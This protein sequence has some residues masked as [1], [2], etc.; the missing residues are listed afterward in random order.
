MGSG[1]NKCIGNTKWKDRVLALEVNKTYT[2]IYE[3]NKYRYNLLKSGKKDDKYY[4][5]ELNLDR[6]VGKRRIGK[7]ENKREKEKEYEFNR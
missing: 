2:Y 3:L 1:G 4:T 7:I 6:Q 5:E